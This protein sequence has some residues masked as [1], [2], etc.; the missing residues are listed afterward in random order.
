MFDWTNY[1]H[2][3]EVLSENPD[4]AS[5]RTAISR[6]YYAIFC[7]AREYLQSKQ[8]SYTDRKSPHE[9]VWKAFEKIQLPIPQKD[10]N[11]IYVI[12]DRL[13][14]RRFQADYD[15]KINN[16]QPKA[17]RTIKEAK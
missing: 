12:G 13:K 15:N 2:L 11:K 3:A 7:N 5:Q 4:E 10:R 16:L 14:K 8:F 1:L 9:A 17:K 6:A